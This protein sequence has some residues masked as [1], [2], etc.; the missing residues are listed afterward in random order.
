MIQ[1]RSRALHAMNNLAQDPLM[2][3]VLDDLWFV[4]V[5]TD[6]LHKGCGRGRGI[7]LHGDPSKG[8]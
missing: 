6:Y 1:S 2:S 4:F 7:A 3:Y 8:T 5:T